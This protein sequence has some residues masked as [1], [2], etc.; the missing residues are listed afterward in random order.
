MR[1]FVPVQDDDYMETKLRAW[2][3]NRRPEISSLITTII[4]LYT[5]EHKS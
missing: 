4:K 2:F 5:S 3:E 1:L